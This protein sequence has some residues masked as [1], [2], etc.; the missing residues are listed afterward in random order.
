[1]TREIELTQGKTALVNNDNYGWLSQWK[2]CA[3]R[4]RHTWYAVRCAK[5]ADGK[6][7]TIGMHREVLGL[8]PQDG[9]QCDHKNGNGLDNRRDNLRP[10]THQENQHN[11]RTR[12]VGTSQ[13][14]GV[15]RSAGSSKWSA[16]ISTPNPE[17]GLGKMRNLGLFTD[18]EGA[19]RAY[20]RAAR[21]HFGEFACT[22]FP[23]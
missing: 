21:E 17:G 4:A 16:N 22:N 2:W 19:A 14:K 6:W 9:T 8:K 20:D 13:F 5:S 15:S 12:G 3:S 11:R 18:E 23:S 10:C 7:T 1:M